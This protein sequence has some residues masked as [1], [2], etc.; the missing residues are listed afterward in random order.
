MEEEDEKE[1]EEEELESVRVSETEFNFL[2][3][4]K[5]YVKTRFQCLPAVTFLQEKKGVLGLAYAL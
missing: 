5:R 3:F 4:I 2:E 1:E